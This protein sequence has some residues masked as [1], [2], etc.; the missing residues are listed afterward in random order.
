VQ[1]H[2]LP[3]HLALVQYDCTAIEKARPVVQMKCHDRYIPKHLYLHV[4]GLNVHIRAICSSIP[5][6]LENHFEK[7]SNSGRPLARSRMARG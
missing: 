2:N 1:V 3:A 4:L 7:R 5:N 6:L